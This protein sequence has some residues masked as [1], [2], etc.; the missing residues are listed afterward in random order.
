MRV[1][2]VIVVIG[3]SCALVSGKI[4]CVMSVSNR[5]VCYLVGFFQ[6]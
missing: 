5:T 1:N 4:D 3:T 2:P 6:P